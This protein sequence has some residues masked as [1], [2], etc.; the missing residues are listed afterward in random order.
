MT[1]EKP[2]PQKAPAL[3][4]SGLMVELSGCQASAVALGFVEHAFDGKALSETAGEPFEEV[5]ERD[6]AR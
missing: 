5:G 4:T 2:S 1:S 6:I 3:R